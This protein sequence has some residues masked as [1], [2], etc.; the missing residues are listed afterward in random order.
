MAR[1]DFY[2]L[3]SAADEARW[4]FAC[5]LTEKAYRL[6]HTVHLLTADRAR[7]EML[8]ELL[9][10]W[11]DGSFVPHVLSADA[12]AEPA[13]VTIGYDAASCSNRCDLLINLSDDQ[14]ANIE[15]FPRVAEIVTS[16]DD[17]RRQGRKRFASYRAQ[18][19]T[20]DT[21]KM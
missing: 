14:P 7:A 12:Q 21:H 17:V 4:Q 16:D 13:P 10:T 3:G 1:I 8:D 11:R 9:W 20:L 5:R 6:G 18:G 2:V 19:H 15:A